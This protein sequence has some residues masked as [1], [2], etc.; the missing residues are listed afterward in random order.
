[1]K[2]TRFDVGLIDVNMP[3]V[4]GLALARAV[5]ARESGT[6]EHLPLIAVTAHAREADRERCRDAGMDAFLS[7]P[8]Q[9]EELVSLMRR[10]LADANRLSGEARFDRGAAL[11]R[12]NGDVDLLAE[13]S[14]LFLEETPQTLKAIE[15]AIAISDLDAVE[16][17]AH[18]LKGALLTLSA[19]RAAKL[20]LALETSAR[21][22]TSSRVPIGPLP[23]R[24][25]ARRAGS[26][27]RS[28]HELGRVELAANREPRTANGYTV[29]FHCPRP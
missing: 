29:P 12:T 17:L 24:D 1:M 7:K 18:R 21:N 15:A 28:R 3:D 26:R 22:P 6:G 5:R 11:I 10:C 13:L 27:A 14:T 2:R 19:E 8:F 23:A 25:R 9:E 16:R 4:D 20:A